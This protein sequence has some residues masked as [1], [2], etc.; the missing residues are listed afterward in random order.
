[1]ISI[2]HIANQIE[3][4]E[5]SNTEPPLSQAG[6]RAESFGMASASAVT[7]VLTT[8]SCIHAKRDSYSLISSTNASPGALSHPSSFNR[9]H[10]SSISLQIYQL[11]DAGIA[12]T[13]LSRPIFESNNGIIYKG[14]TK[15]K[16][17]VVFKYWKPT[18]LSY[19]YSVQNEYANLKACLHKNV[20]Q[21]CDLVCGDRE[22]DIDDS[23]SASESKSWY[24]ILPFYPRG[25]LLNC[26]SVL[27]KHKIVLSNTIKDSI[28]KQILKGIVYLHDK[29]IVHRD[30]KPENFLIDNLGVIKIGD[31]GY[32]LDTRNTAA[33]AMLRENPK[34]LFS[35]TLSFKAPELFAI[36]HKYDHDQ[37]L[38]LEATIDTINFKALDYW[39]LGIVYFNISIMLVP[40]TTAL[41]DNINYHRYQLNYPRGDK[42]FEK[43]VKSFDNTLVNR[44]MASENP[45]LSCFKKLTYDCRESILRLLNPHIPERLSPQELLTS[46]WMRQVYAKA[47]D[48]IEILD[49]VK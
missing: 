1:M 20:V 48:L 7:D 38:D 8:S 23:E 24:M 27:R 32:S 6:P 36:E 46:R 35:G 5:M 44:T 45:A 29:D 10:S 12:Y 19:R 16:T 18:S 37:C 11:S 40:W 43:F 34:D 49:Q 30:L 42:A 33:M 26:L 13:R 31:F 4:L 39:S 15:D 21:V 2:P 47:E 22:D 3:Q 9:S 28:F 14:L 25:D 41:S 17:P